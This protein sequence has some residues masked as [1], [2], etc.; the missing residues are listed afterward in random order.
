V[1]GEQIL[2]VT[3]VDV[4]FHG[5]MRFADGVIAQVDTGLALPLRHG[6]EIV[7]TAGTI[8]V[9]DPWFCH[10]PSIELTTDDGT[11]LIEVGAASSYELQIRNFAA[12]VRGEAS[13]LLG[14]EDALGQARAI[15][16]LYKSADSGAVEDTKLA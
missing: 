2:G 12:A 14:R 5:V 4:R 10:S 13:P 16:A 15:E 3:G 7:G 6:L 8:M 1:Y 11:T 9:R